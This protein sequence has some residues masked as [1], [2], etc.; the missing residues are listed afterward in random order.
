MGG[1]R[2]AR[3]ALF[4]TIPDMLSIITILSS[5]L[6]QI[7]CFAAACAVMRIPVML[8]ANTWVASLA[9][10]L[11]IDISRHHDELVRQAGL[12]QALDDAKVNSG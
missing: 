9:R 6:T 7:I 12:G 8:T 2:I 10:R 1:E 4:A 11:R 5:C 3:P